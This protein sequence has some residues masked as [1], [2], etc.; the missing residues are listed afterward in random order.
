MENKDII[1]AIADVDLI[2]PISPKE[3]R[4]AMNKQND[5]YNELS[6]NFIEYAVAVNTDRAI[7]NAVD[8][9]KPVAKRILYEAFIKGFSSGKPHVKCAN[10]V[11]NT[12]AD[13]HPHGDS[14]IYGALARLSQNW[15][16]RYPLIDFHGSNGNRDGDGPAAYRYT[17]ARLGKLVED[18]MLQGI[19]KNTV[20]FIPNYSETMDEPVSLPSI[21]P[22]LLCN[23]N[24]GIGV[25]MACNFLPHNLREVAQAI[26]DYIDGKTPTL[27]GPDFPTGGIIINKNDIP[28]IMKTGHGT[29]KVRGKYEIDGHKIIFTELPYGVATEAVMD[30]INAA[31]E[32]EK[33][34]GITDIRNESNKKGF[35]LA[36]ECEKD[37]NLKRIIENL[38][39]ETSLQTAISYNQVALVNKTPTE[40][41]LEQCIKIYVEYNS[42]CIVREAR[43]DIKKATERLHIIIGLIKA[44]DIIDDIIAMIK[45]SESAAAAKATLMTKW[46]FSEEQ[47]KAI[48]DMKLSR[49]AKL[50][51]EE[52]EQEKR[53]LEALLLKLAA[54]CENPIP[55]LQKRLA[56]IVAKYGDDRRTELIQIDAQT[57]EEKEIINVEPEKCVVIMTEDGYIKRIPATSFKTQRRNGKG[58]KTKGDIVSTIIRTNTIDSLMVFT[59]KGR[60]YRILVDDIPV[61]TNTQKGQN[62]SALIKMENGETATLIY[63]IYRDTDADYVLFVTENG[64]VKKT[65]LKEY[66]GTKKKSGVIALTLKENDHLAKVNLI[67]DEQIILLT[68]NGKAIRMQS[69]DIAPSSRTAVGIKGITLDKEDYMIDAL[70]IRDTNDNI[71][72][73]SESGLGKK[74]NL[75][76]LPTQNRAGKGLIVYK[77]DPLIGGCLVQDE[78]IVLIAGSTTSICIS[79]SEIPLLSRAASGNM[80][81]KGSKIT[82]ISKV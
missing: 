76:E 19:K 65:S 44:L 7:P 50:E 80:M 82:S 71:A 27:P 64:I 62:L 25:A 39:R 10:I 14:S 72:L 54:I 43:F 13:L 22:N 53:E 69:T 4:E 21:F 24:T 12:M 1:N 48:L 31:C 20:D 47:A 63:S 3:L 15:V 8:G 9:L 35:R 17:E 26:N 51:K 6:Q 29:V 70:V 34:K 41:N 38:F 45:A 23:P 52:L 28:L 5:L 36:L 74:I 49:L 81:I 32:E 61:G 57:K 42:N 75:S 66:T 2:N 56:A 60:M 78:D 37:A 77:G 16:M 79:G 30:E 11:G 55:E 58:I 67:K 73:F 18:G 33:I 46:G 68:H 59:N 40:L